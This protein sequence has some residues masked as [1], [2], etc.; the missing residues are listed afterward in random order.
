M[1]ERI[2]YF[3]RIQ[4]TPNQYYY[5]F[6]FLIGLFLTSFNS[7]AQYT[8]IINS[9]TPGRTMGAYTVGEAVY[10]LES[11]YSSDH[12][13]HIYPD[14]DYHINDIESTFRFGFKERVELIYEF[15]HRSKI[16]HTQISTQK[17]YLRIVS[18]LKF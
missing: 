1:L 7:R 14:S 15:G 9:N 5:C 8:D 10:Q 3:S 17:A 12:Q 4:T 2:K 11:L 18:D 16:D 6:I 13:T